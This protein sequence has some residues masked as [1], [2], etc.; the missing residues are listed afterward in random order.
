V[1]GFVR[2]PTVECGCCS[3]GNIADTGD[4]ISDLMVHSKALF[5]RDTADNWIPGRQWR[6][7]STRA[8]GVRETAVEFWV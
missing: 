3:H 2:D 6:D 4:A 8:K 5:R 7:A 1:R